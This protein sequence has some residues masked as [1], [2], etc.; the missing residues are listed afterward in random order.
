MNYIGS[1]LS[2]LGFLEESINKVVDKNCSVFCDLFAGTGIVGSYFKKKGYKV[3]AND[4][5]YYSY[6]LNRHYIGNHK[7][8]GFS[9]LTT[10]I[11]ELKNIKV[12]KRKNFVCSYLSDLKGIKGFVYNNYCFGGTENQNEPRQYFSDENGMRC[13]AVRQKIEKWKKEKLISDDEYYFLI[14]SLVESIDKYANTA[15]VYGAFLKK[16]KKTAQNSLVLKPAELIIN[17]QTHEVFNEDINKVSAKVQGDILYLD[18]P[19]NHRQYATN[20]HLLETIAKYDNPVIHGK[21]GLRE[22]QNQKSLYCS[23]TQ[24]KKAFRDLI[25]KAKV[26]YIFLSYNNEGLMSL[27]DIKEIMSLRG[28]YGYF[29]KDY[30]RFKADRAENREYK[31]EKTVEYLHYVVCN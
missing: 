2:L 27:D 7:E 30:N 10:E 23:R 28:E 18:P 25:L 13:D 6:V 24:V 22:Y 19:Y 26:K 12:E 16:L 21:T 11:P 9:A 17:D 31:A 8:L 15:S 3:I 1:K 29:T 14:T 4:I 20:Y 5:Q